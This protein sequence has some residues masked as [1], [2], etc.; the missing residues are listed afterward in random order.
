M[1]RV[2]QMCHI[3]AKNHQ[4][5]CRGRRGTRSARHVFAEEQFGQGHCSVKYTCP[6]LNKKSPALPRREISL[7]IN[8][9]STNY[10]PLTFF[11]V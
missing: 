10:N 2:A 11:D 8:L 6:S 5:G 7:K 1:Q 9:I 4:K 3:C